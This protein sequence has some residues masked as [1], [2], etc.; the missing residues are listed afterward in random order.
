MG[1]CAGRGCSLLPVFSSVFVSLCQRSPSISL[2]KVP[3]L[4]ALWSVTAMRLLIWDIF[5]EIP[6]EAFAGAAQWEPF[7]GGK[8]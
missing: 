8:L 2:S 4:N 3:P 6:V 1:S 7:R 5:T